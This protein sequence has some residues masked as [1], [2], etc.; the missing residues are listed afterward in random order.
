MT[1]DLWSSSST[2]VPSTSRIISPASNNYM[3]LQN[4]TKRNSRNENPSK[5]NNVKKR[6]EWIATLP[7]EPLS[8]T[9]R[10]FSLST[11]KYSVFPSNKLHL[12]P[13]LSMLP[14]SYSHLSPVFPSHVSPSLPLLQ[15]PPSF[16][17]LK[18]K[19]LLLRP[20]TSAFPFCELQN[21]KWRK[22]RKRRGEG[23]EVITVFGINKVLQLEGEG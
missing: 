21:T 6:E 23:S 8:P 13:T 19:V 22:Y 14:L 18:S 7:P 3:T 4:K 1:T 12:A 16:C 5:E 20:P 11:S 17:A 10:T 2:F 9:P 15:L